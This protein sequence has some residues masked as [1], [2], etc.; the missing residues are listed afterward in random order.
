MNVQKLIT[1]RSCM[2]VEESDGVSNFVHNT[3]KWTSPR[4]KSFTFMQEMFGEL[5]RVKNLNR[6]KILVREP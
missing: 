3:P 5:A 4:T 1:V 6:V 2:F